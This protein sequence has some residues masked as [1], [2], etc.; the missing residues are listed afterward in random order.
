VLLSLKNLSSKGE[1][2]LL[3]TLDPMFKEFN[4]IFLQERIEIEQPKP[5]SQVILLGD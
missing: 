4:K 5:K 1:Y 3:L 2:E